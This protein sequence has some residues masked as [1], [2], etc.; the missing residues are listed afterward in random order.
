M[1]ERTGELGKRTLDNVRQYAGMLFLSVAAAKGFFVERGRGRRQFVRTV[2]NQIYFTCVEPLPFFALTA[3]TFGIVIVQACDTLLPR[4]GLQ[5][6]VPILIVNALV[7]EVSPLIVAMVL[8]GR[9]GPAIATELGYMRLNQ[10]IDAL[11]LAGINT[12][13]FMVL[14]RIVGVTLATIFAMISFATIAVIG[15]FFLGEMLTINSGTLLLRP[16]FEAIQL[17]TIAFALVKA[18][19]FGVTIAVVNCY[20]GLGVQRSFTEIPRANVH[21]VQHSLT[22]CFLVNALVSVYALVRPA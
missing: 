9:S 12:D 22:I 15:G 1:L 21:G 17:S 20:H 10:E 2:A 19:F 14:P 18:T 11:D 16:I 13:Y 3:L 6:Y 4:Y 7:R 8:I 5:Q